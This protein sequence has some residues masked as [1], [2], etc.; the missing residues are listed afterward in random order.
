MSIFVGFI[1]VEGW[2]KCWP[3]CCFMEEYGVAQVKEN[4]FSKEHASAQRKVPGIIKK[5]CP[6]LGQPISMDI[7]LMKQSKMQ[8][9]ATLILSLNKGY[10][11]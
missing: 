6:T 8:F 5:S 7:T 9:Q 10:S 11:E 3:F 4:V 2:Q 1:L